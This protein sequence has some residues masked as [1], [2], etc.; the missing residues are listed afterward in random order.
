MPADPPTATVRRTPKECKAL[1]LFA[2]VAT[3]GPW[4]G[5]LTLRWQGWDHAWSMPLFVLA[6]GCCSLGGV[7]ALAIEHGPRNLPQ[8]IGRRLAPSGGWTPWLMVL[9]WGPVWMAMAYALAAVA[10]G[11]GVR[12]RWEQLSAFTSPAVLWLF[13][14]GP[15]GEEFGWRGYL[16]PA[17]LR[18]WSLARCNLVIGVAWALWHW[19]LML[20]RWSGEPLHL[21]YFV[22][23]VVVFSF[24][25]SAVF[26]RGGLLPT[27]AVHCAINASQEVVPSAFGMQG[28]PSM[29]TALAMGGTLWLLAAAGCRALERLPARQDLAAPSCLQ[30]EARA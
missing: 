10:H 2:L 9:L 13:L 30:T 8:V 5:W 28:P 25:L 4:T 14:T 15:L 29:P 27:M 16:L 17:L 24:M 3:L 19:P 26:L 11:R 18:R 1:A 6:G 12:P 21:P 22:A 23:N 20:D 7:A